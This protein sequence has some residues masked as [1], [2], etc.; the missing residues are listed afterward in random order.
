MKP[1][2]TSGNLTSASHFSGAFRV[3]CV[4]LFRQ[5]KHYDNHLARTSKEHKFR[6]SKTQRSRK[7]AQYL[8]CTNPVA[9]PKIHF[10]KPMRKYYH[11]RIC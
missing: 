1:P 4:E 2:K 6:D 5:R 10:Q 8:N 11:V 7:Y 3:D 9:K